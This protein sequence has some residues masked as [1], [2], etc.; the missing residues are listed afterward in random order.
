MRFCISDV[1]RY[2]V[3]VDDESIALCGR[4]NYAVHLVW[5]MTWFGFRNEDAEEEEFDS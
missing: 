3:T 1:R 2:W 4:L 5:E